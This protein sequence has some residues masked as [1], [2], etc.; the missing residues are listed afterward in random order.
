MPMIF[1]GGRRIA[2]LTITRTGWAATVVVTLAVL[3]LFWGF[4]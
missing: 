1:V 4:A 3:A 2:A